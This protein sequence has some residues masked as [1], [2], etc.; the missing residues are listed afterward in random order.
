MLNYS[1]TG[2]MPNN[3]ITS[4]LYNLK[5]QGGNCN[6]Y[7]GIGNWPDTVDA[8]TYPVQTVTRKQLHPGIQYIGGEFEDTPKETLYLSYPSINNIQ[9]KPTIYDIQAYANQQTN[10]VAMY[11]YQTSQ[12]AKNHAKNYQ[13]SCTIDEN[14]S[15]SCQTH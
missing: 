12:D 5:C 4:Q 1:F 6:S 9:V 7:W 8:T 10:V 15:L 14:S 3:L 2:T 13:Y 11:F